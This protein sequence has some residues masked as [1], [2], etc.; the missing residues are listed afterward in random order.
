M[1]N[2]EQMKKEKSR[3]VRCYQATELHIREAS[4][5]DAPSRIIAGYAILFGV[6]SSPLWSDAAFCPED[7][8]VLKGKEK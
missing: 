4:E 3:F 2:K 1:T 8:G 5:G 6:E 7:P